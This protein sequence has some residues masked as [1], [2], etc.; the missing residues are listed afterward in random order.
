MLAR[1]NLWLLDPS[2]F[3]V[4]AEVAHEPTFSRPGEQQTVMPA[5]AL[6]REILRRPVTSS[7]ETL[8]PAGE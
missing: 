5:G 7:A 3:G 6:A 4:C 8:V 2:G 1:P